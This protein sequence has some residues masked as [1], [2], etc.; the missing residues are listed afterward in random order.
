MPCSTWAACTDSFE[1]SLRLYLKQDYLCVLRSQPSC[2]KTS[3]KKRDDTKRET[4]KAETAVLFH[5]MLVLLLNKD[6]SP[7]DGLSSAFSVLFCSATLTQTQQTDTLSSHPSTNTMSNV[8]FTSENSSLTVDRSRGRDNF[9]LICAQ[10]V[11]LQ[12]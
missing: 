4:G 6:N 5:T 12:V 8:L 10:F 7:D 2:A 11:A 1:H 3:W 9:S